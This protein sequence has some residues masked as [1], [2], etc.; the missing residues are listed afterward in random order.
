MRKC[1]T[2]WSRKHNLVDHI[3]NMNVP[4][5][6]NFILQNFPVFLSLDSLE[7]SIVYINESKEYGNRDYL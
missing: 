2:M 3:M 6:S 5:K 4:T 1:T 7:N